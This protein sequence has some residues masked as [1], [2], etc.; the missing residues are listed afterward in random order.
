MQI[1]TVFD[2]EQPVQMNGEQCRVVSIRAYTGGKNFYDL[3][4]FTTGALMLD[5][6]EQ[7]LIQNNQLES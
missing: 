2:I 4:N 5:I 3:I 6:S 1:N 7:D